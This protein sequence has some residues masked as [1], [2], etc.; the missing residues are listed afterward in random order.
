MIGIDLIPAQ[1]PRGVS[2]I[3]G[4]FLSPT[5]QRLVKD[6]V[7]ES[8]RRRQTLPN[9]ADESGSSDDQESSDIERPS[10]ID[11]ERRASQVPKPPSTA[12]EGT[13]AECLVDVSF[14]CLETM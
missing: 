2:T 3:Q 7:S 12:P 4:D 10:Y 5:V 8:D 11:L 13:P 9:C 1:P 14:T 6:L